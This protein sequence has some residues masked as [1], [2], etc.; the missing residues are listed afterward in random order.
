M[1][2]PFIAFWVLIAIG[3]KDL[4]IKKISCFVAIWLVLLLGFAYLNISPYYFVAPQTL[5][6][7]ILILM[8]FGRDINIR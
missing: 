3:R 1:A 7:S 2:I 4:G 5:L 6:D 8:L